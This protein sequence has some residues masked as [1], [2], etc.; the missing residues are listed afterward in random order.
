[1]VVGLTYDLRSEYLAMGYGEEETAEFDRDDTVVAIESAIAALGHTTVRIG[2]LRSLM[3]RLSDGERWDMV[4]NIAEGMHGFGRESQVPSLLEAF[5]IPCTFADS[6]VLGIAL[7]KSMCKH[8]V[9]SLGINTPD[10]ALVSGL[11]DIDSIRMKFPLFAKPVAEG[12]SKGVTDMSVI[13]TP[14]QLREMCEHLLKTFRQPVLVERFLPG[15]EFTVGIVGTG[16]SAWA[17]GA[18]EVL[19]RAKVER[20][21][22]SYTNKDQCE[23]LI[24]YRMADDDLARRS[25]DLALRTWRGLECRD[26]GR[27]DV[28]IDDAGEPSFIEVNPLAG[29]HPEHSDLPIMWSKTGRNYPDLI[30]EIVT[31]TATRIKHT[32]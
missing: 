11:A 32:T 29:L 20:A 12:T 18:M 8:V 23:E 7:H 1:M 14:K 30:R 24:D 5:E 3:R 31:S 9:R 6:V 25:C 10:F 26:S 16:D 22:Y 15:R 21:V 19:T 4:F 28:R 13:D 27:V 2:H 17:V